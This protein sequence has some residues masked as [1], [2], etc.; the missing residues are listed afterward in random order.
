MVQLNRISAGLLGTVFSRIF[1]L[2]DENAV[3]TVAPEIMPTTSPWERDEFWA[4][5]GGNL[6]GWGVYVAAVAA[7]TGAAQLRNPTSSGMILIVERI[8]IEADAAGVP[9]YQ[10]V[11]MNLSS[12]M[13]TLGNAA[14]S[15]HRDARRAP[16]NNVIRG[17]AGRVTYGTDAALIVPQ[18][19]IWKPPRIIDQTWVI[20]PGFCLQIANSQANVAMAPGFLWREKPIVASEQLTY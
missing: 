14:D 19:T 20:P 7:Q 11:G 13:T 17:I 18:Q 9:A 4:L 12:A 6:C 15:N 2:S 1:T 5:T 3:Q 10:Y 16:G 8:Q